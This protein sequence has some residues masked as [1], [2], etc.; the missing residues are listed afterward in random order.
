[1][2]LKR[3]KWSFINRMKIKFVIAVLSVFILNTFSYSQLKFNDKQPELKK[4]AVTEKSNIPSG[5]LIPLIFF[6]FINPMLVIENKKAYFGLTK[7]V[8]AGIYP[9]GRLAF[10]YSYIFRDY[11]A[12]HLR[13]SYNYDIVA[14]S[15]DFMAGLISP[16]VGYFT[17]TH[18]SGVFGQLTFSLLFPVHITG[19]SSGLSPYFRIR[20]TYVTDGIK[21]NIF[22][23]SL[24]MSFVLSY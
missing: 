9:F 14:G 17:D 18:N 23:I 8:S 1:M 19:E 11:S 22:D 5:I 24:G 4:F 6:S 21:H 3:A 10:E 2:T 15:G 16:G 20:D 13:L 7:E 12:S